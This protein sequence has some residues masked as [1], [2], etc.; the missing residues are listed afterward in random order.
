MEND[1]N[2]KTTLIDKIED[3]EHNQNNKNTISNKKIYPI[4]KKNKESIEDIKIFN[5]FDPESGKYIRK[6]VRKIKK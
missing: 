2:K 1:T 6:I 5:I 4:E 3:K